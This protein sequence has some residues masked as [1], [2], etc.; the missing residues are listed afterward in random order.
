MLIGGI[1]GG[2]TKFVCGIGDEKGNII[3]RESFP[4]TTPE[5]TM[6]KVFNFFK[7]SN[8]ERL[9]LT[10]FGPVDLNKKNSTYGCIMNTP[11]TLWKNYDI[12]GATKK[13]FNIPIGFDNDV[14][15]AALA[16]TIFG[17]EKIDNC[18]YITIGTGIGGGAV[19]DGKMVHGLLH[20]EMGHSK[21][22]RHKNETIECNC[23]Y[24]TDCLEGFTAGPSILKRYGV[25]GQNLPPDHEVWDILA[26]YLAQGIVNITMILSPEKIVLGGGV[27]KQKQIYPLI[28]KYFKEG[29]NDYLVSPKF[30]NMENYICYTSLG[31]NAGLLGALAIALQEN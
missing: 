18:V 6:E 23:P 31:D 7:D 5:E 8:I 9:G 27:A 30:E 24:H 1:E 4:T 10:T 16:E 21:V 13:V 12:L 19:V 11:K 20:P 29:I 25:E 15:G 22:V 14:N 26:Y 3:K 17:N 28:Y 2:G